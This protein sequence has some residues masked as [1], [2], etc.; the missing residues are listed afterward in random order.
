MSMAKRCRLWKLG[1]VFSLDEDAVVIACLGNIARICVEE[2][3][4]AARLMM[5]GKMLAE[6][7]IT[8]VA[9]LTHSIIMYCMYIDT[10]RTLA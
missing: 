4:K 8:A 6:W 3:H 5:E 10:V 9:L 7:C 1:E 2:D